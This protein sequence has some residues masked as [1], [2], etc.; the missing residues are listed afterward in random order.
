MMG[1]KEFKEKVMQDEAF[2]AKFKD[3]KTPEAVVAIAVQ[4]G[5]TFTVEDIKNN[6]ELTDAELE[7]AAGGDSIFAKTYFVTR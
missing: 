3:A 5:F 1:V 4:E 6:T 2:A 7:S